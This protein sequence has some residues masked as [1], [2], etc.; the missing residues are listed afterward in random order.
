MIQRANKELEDLAESYH[1][2]LLKELKLLYINE[3]LLELLLGK[4]I[5]EKDGYVLGFCSGYVSGTKHENQA[6]Y[7]EKHKPSAMIPEGQ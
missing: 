3:D 6:T 2:D 1:S 4:I 5:S 7:C